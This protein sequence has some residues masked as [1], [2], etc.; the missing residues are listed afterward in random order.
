MPESPLLHILIAALA[1]LLIGSF[2]NVCIYRLPRN[3]S[4]IAP[5][6]FCPSCDATI[7]WYDNIP[8]LSYCI[9][10]GH[11]RQCHDAIPMHYLLVELTTG[12]L[13]AF[14]VAEYG[15]T[16]VSLKWVVFASILVALFWTDLQN[17]ML[18]D[19]L[20]L[21]GSVLGLIFAVFIHLP[22]A[23]AQLVFPAANP[24][25][26][27]LCNATI[28]AILLAGPLWLVARL[29]YRVRGREGLGLGDVKLLILCG[30]FQGIRDGLLTL[31]IGAVAGSVIGLVYIWFARK[32]AG[33]YELPFGAFLCAAA[34]VVVLLLPPAW[35]PI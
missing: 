2:L 15:W 23:F 17:R 21:G 22:S 34:L 26:Q 20:T 25:V 29:Y 32:Q 18:P 14:T 31:L 13:F 3:L 11:C 4:V 33:T 30:L 19:E 8:V 28:S 5:R 9:L 35:R 16:L 12:L 1:G 10:R 7:P 27:S 24:I 6:S